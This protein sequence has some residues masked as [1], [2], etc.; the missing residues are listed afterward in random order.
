MQ[1]HGLTAE[2]QRDFHAY[3]HKGADAGRRSSML[4][5]KLGQLARTRT[6]SLGPADVVQ[7][8]ADT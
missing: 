1:A 2:K 6:H 5:R 3:R 7:A 8:A 4:L